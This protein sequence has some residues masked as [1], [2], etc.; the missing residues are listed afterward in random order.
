MLKNLSLCIDLHHNGIQ[1]PSDL[2]EVAEALKKLTELQG[3]SLMLRWVHL[4]NNTVDKAAIALADGLKQLRNL[5]ALEL[6]LYQN[7]SF[8]ELAPLFKSNA[9]F[10][11]LKL[12]RESPGGKPDD[13]KLINP[14]HPMR[15]RTKNT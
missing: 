8:S 11:E 15:M 6:S 13:V 2:I 10:Q 14:L 9:Q 7:G 5:S 4:G 12:E 1:G 3:L